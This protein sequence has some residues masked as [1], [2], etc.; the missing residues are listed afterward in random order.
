MNLVFLDIDGVLNNLGSVLGLG[1]PSKHFDP[2]SVALVDRLCREGN[3]SIVISSS[4]R[5]GKPKPLADEIAKAGGRALVDR[6]IGETP[7][8]GR[9]RGEEVLQFL[10]EWEGSGNFVILDDDN[11][12]LPGQP[13]VQ[14]TFEDGFRY[15]HYVA[16]LRHLNPDHEDCQD[17]SIVVPAAAV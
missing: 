12:M 13:F 8:L 7:Y 17:R 10:L 11:D 3:A 2:V 1:N 9:R 5:R 16:A 4:W 6:I 14:T 15:R